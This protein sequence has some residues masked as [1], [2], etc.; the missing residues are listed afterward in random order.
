MK[1]YL[2]VPYSEKDEAKKLGAR[3]DSGKK[4]WFAEN[5][6]H[7]DKFL[8]WMPERLRLPRETRKSTRDV[9]KPIKQR[10]NQSKS[11][12]SNNITTTQ[13]GLTIALYDDFGYLPW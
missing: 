6:E 5:V 12:F 9:P 3:W 7:L 10:G 4:K 13:E 11:S 2:N 8:R 1:T